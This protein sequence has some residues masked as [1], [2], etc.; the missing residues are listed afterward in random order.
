MDACLDFVLEVECGMRVLVVCRL[1]GRLLLV[2][3]GLGVV[4]LDVREPRSH[5]RDLVRWSDGLGADT[6]LMG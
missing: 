4:F 2:L 3:V 5:S 1:L 6:F